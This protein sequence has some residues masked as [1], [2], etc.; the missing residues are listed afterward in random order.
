MLLFAASADMITTIH[1]LIL[2]G[3]YQFYEYKYNDQKKEIP[4]TSWIFLPMYIL[5]S[6]EKIF[7]AFIVSPSP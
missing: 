4:G 2:I 1:S 6:R 7:P 5:R 3:R